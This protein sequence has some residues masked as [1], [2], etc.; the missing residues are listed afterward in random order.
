MHLLSMIE[1]YLAE[2]GI[3]PSRFG[4]D[5]MGDPGFVGTLRRG[6]LP[7]DSTVERVTAYIRTARA[8][9]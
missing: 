6:R 5:A 4:R 7:R 8:A 9:R 2:S 1:R 3:T